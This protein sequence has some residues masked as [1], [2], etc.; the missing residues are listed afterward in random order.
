MGEK[1]QLLAQVAQVPALQKATTTLTSELSESRSFT[2]RLETRVEG[3]EK[4][5]RGLEKEVDLLVKRGKE[6]KE[7]EVLKPEVEKLREEN[8]TMGAALKELKEKVREDSE[9]EGGRVQ[10]VEGLLE[11]VRAR[12]G[13]LE[14]EVGRLKTVS[15]TFI[16]VSCFDAES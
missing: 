11:R 8:R 7:L 9:M 15:W 1:S 3:L 13:V 12:E 6:L 14:R 2:Q 16:S 5:R 10:E 4:E